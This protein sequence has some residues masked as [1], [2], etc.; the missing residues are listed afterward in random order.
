MHRL[1][2]CVATVALL[3]MEVAYTAP[4]RLA[5]PFD[6]RMRYLLAW[7][8]A[9]SDYS[10][11]VPLPLV[12]FLLPE[13]INY[14]Y[15]SKTK[16]GYRGQSDI[17]ALYDGYRQTI[18]L[19]TSFD[20]RFDEHVLVHELVHHLQHMH[21]RRFRC[22]EEREREAYLIQRRYVQE[23]GLGVMPSWAFIMELRC[24]YK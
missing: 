3:F 15:Y 1:M 20:I 11:D 6:T 14:R 18:A 4:G 13:Q 8:A 10:A 9:R 5:G 19:P 22:Q 12:Q 23:A 16:S 7:I 2:L 24:T 21:G 17:Y